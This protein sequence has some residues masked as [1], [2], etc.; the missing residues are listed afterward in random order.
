MFFSGGYVALPTAAFIAFFQ[1]TFIEAVAL[2]KVLNI[3]SSLGR[4]AHLCSGRPGRLAAGPDLERSQ[5]CRRVIR[6]DTRPTR[7]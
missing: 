3:F 2:T 7:E 6:S 5:L 4:H 1:L